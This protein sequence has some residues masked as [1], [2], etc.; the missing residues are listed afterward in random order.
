MGE[1]NVIKTV[2]LKLIKPKGSFLKD[3][4]VYTEHICGHV[5]ETPYFKTVVNSLLKHILVIT[6]KCQKST[7]SLPNQWVHISLTGAKKLA[8][9]PTK[10]LC[11]SFLL[12]SFQSCRVLKLDAAGL[13]KGK[14]RE[15]KN[16]ADEEVAQTAVAT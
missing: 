1:K 15:L 8:P 4:L 12:S 6:L 7:T 10:F 16:E 2:F 11:M 5:L 3:L 9:Y 14:P 13:N